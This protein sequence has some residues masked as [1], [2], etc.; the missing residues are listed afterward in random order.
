MIWNTSSRIADASYYNDPR[1]MA[2]LIGGIFKS[3]DENAMTGV[4]EINSECHTIGIK[5]QVCELCGGRGTMV[6][7][8]IDAGGLDVDDMDE[9]ACQ[10]YYNGAYDV[11]CATCKGKR[12]EPVPSPRN[13]SETAVLAEIERLERQ[14][15][16][17]VAEQR[18]EFLA[19]A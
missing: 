4:V 17:S 10:A 19:G 8:S 13:E 1:V 16:A 6:S 14:L 9:E 5:Y 15:A 12:V 11:A 3:V 18:A 2:E 7:P